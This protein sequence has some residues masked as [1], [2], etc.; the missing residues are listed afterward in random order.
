[1]SILVVGAGSIGQL[2]GHC[3]ARGGAQVGVYVRPRYTDEAHSGYRLYDLRRG[4]DAPETFSPDAV[5]SR[6]EELSATDH[7]AVLLCIPSDGLRGPW[8][9]DFCRAIGDTPI[10]SLTPG[11]GDR[12]YL[13]QY[14]ADE[15][16][17]IGLITAISYPCP[18]PGETVDEPG[19]AYWLP[20]LA[21]AYFEGPD[22]VL[23]P[24]T[25]PLGNGG[26]KARKIDA[27]ATRSAFG[28]SLL[29]PFIAALESTGWSLPKLRRSRDRRR[30]L[31]RACDEALEAVES[32][33]DARRP[34]P[35]RFLG[36]TNWRGLL[37]VAPWFPPFDLEVY[38]Q[39][40]FTKV[41]KQTRMMLEDYID[42]RRE[43]GLDSPALQQ[44]LRHIEE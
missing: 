23:R 10:I 5:Y 41:G 12:D 16:L 28:S 9:E 29:I 34:F 3:L 20:P 1:M 32:K 8:L 19:T 22:E 25:E 11:L 24:V 38:L 37:T 21:P 42:R 39:V 18:M 35:V 30:L 7:D 15:C 36:P 26:M 43:D 40:H 4:F 14:V 2:Y 33:L 27:V 6:P 31:A 13:R 17:G 44:L